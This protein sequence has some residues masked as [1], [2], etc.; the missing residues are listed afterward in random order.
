MKK[1]IEFLKKSNRYKHLIGGFG[2]GLLACSPW[3]ALYSA[4]IAAT[5]LE[6]KDKM[7]ANAYDWTDWLLMAGGGI[8]A[9]LVWS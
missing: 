2:V 8:L 1:I 6:A 5:C 9:M 3:A 4:I 7:Y